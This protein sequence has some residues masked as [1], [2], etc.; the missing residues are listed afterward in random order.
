MHQ[1]FEISIYHDVEQLLYVQL[2][3]RS[4]TRNGALL[5]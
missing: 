1:D 2:Q 3:A 5:V 4:S